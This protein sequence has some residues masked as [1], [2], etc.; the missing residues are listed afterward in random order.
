[1]KTL[2]FTSFAL[3][4]CMAIMPVHANSDNAAMMPVKSGISSYIQ[5]NFE[6]FAQELDI[7]KISIDELCERPNET[8]LN[9]AQV[10]FQNA[11]K[12]FA[13]IEFIRLGPLSEAHYSERFLFW[14]DRQGIAL[15]QV[16][17]VLN[18]KNPSVL[19]LDGLDKKSV[20]LQGFGTLEFI[21]FGT[22]YEALKTNDGGF[23]CKFAKN[24]ST[25]LQDRAKQVASLWENRDGFVKLWEN[26]SQENPLFRNDLEAL[27]AL[28]G[29]IAQGMELIRDLRIRPILGRAN[30]GVNPKRALLWRS[31]M[32]FEIIRSNIQGLFDLWTVSHLGS[33]LDDE[34]KWLQGS[35]A[36]EFNNA[37]EALDVLDGSVLDVKN[38]DAKISKLRYLMIVT[39]SLQDMI[40]EQYA[41]QAG[42]PSTFSSLDGD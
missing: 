41:A 6:R 25:S 40:G 21:L 29:V 13:R 20:A 19:T 15:K 8:A 28:V 23:R 14:P 5:P 26:P 42:L 9:T 33:L 38:N 31:N 2:K 18:K 16:Q 27:G 37:L 1:M 10:T 36:F 7:L 32:S 3:A 30:K 35:I 22:G 11:I 17:R 24:L 4:L 39:L 12:S 34:N